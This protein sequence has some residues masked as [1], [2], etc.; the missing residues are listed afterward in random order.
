MAQQYWIG[1]F[2]IDLSRNQITQ[3][4]QKQTLAPKAL[5]VLTYLAKNKG[6]VVSHDEL[7]GAVWPN[8]VVSPNTLQRCIAQLRKALG[9]DGKVQH[10]IKTHSK[11][12]YSLEVDVRW[13]EHDEATAPVTSNGNKIASL[14]Q[15][16]MSTAQGERRSMIIYCIVALSIMTLV[17]L[18]YRFLAPKQQLQLEV[19]EI[20]PLTSTDNR[21]LASIYSPD[22]NYVVFKRFPE[23]LCVN[24]LWAK[25]LNTQEEFQ[26]TNKLGSYGSLSFSPDGKTLAFIQTE[27]C[28]KPVTQARCFQLQSLD[29]DKA[30]LAPTEP[31]TLLEC[32][33]SEIR[34]PKWLNDNDIA[35]LQQA[36]GQRQLISYSIR[37][38]KSKVISARPGSDLI[39]YDYSPQLNLIVTTSIHSDGFHYIEAIKPGGQQQSRHR[40]SYPE[41][42]PRF[43]HLYPNFSPFE[44]QLIFS[45]G[46]QLF[47]LS[48]EGQISPVRLPLDEAIGGPV[49]HPDGQR[50]LAIKGHYDS[51]VVAATLPSLTDNSNAFAYRTIERSTHREDDAQFQPN[52]DLIAYSSQRTG[53]SQVWIANGSQVKQLSQFPL[54]AYVQELIWSD[55][56]QEVLVNV[57]GE[58]KRLNLA[59]QETAI[60]FEQP[61]SRLYHWD[62]NKQVALAIMRVGGIKRLVEL[63]LNHLESQ[64]INHK[65][66]L[67]AD[68]SESGQ[69]I[70]MD[71]MNRFWQSGAVEDQLIE[72]LAGHGSDKHFVIKNNVIYGIN[73]GFQ[74]WRYALNSGE[75][76]IIGALPDTIDAITDLSDQQLLLTMRVEARKEVV[77]LFW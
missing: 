70:Y 16:P 15:S 55:D 69:L 22:G 43:R 27:D 45:T 77:E 29:F 74:L 3:T 41:Q 24:N 72:A 30:L 67:W 8:T 39:A 7:L 51:D 6:K 73:S 33:S 42:I 38:H 25:N 76:H 47:M 5:A 31:S 71:E 4:E 44:N 56:G 63:N 50:M 53:S 37:D 59:G 58:L 49:F 34:S 54:D 19:T 64:I 46:R 57:S 17:V 14:D 26:L 68:K 62:S 48:L 52:G 66:V 36:S 32:K 2:H 65:A 23:V 11:K 61:I 40:I 35:L 10:Y 21:E 12:G 60:P 13:Q 20:R 9:D 28:T 1:D 75:F 18:G